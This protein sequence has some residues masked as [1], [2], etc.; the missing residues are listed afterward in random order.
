MRDDEVFALVTV[1]AT[2]LLGFK[3][4]MTHQH[5]RETLKTVQ[6]VVE[7]GHLDEGTR[8]VLADS[9]VAESRR[10]REFWQMVGRHGLPFLRRTMFVASWLC[11]VIS[12]CV[13]IAMLATD[14]S[15]WE[16]QGAGIFTAI[17]FGLITVPMAMREIEGRRA[18]VR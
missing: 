18:P 1:M 6:K 10:L 8:R 14:A 3:M 2:G 7:S 13:L 4:W 17:G 9:L 15:R 5:R 12:G 16:I 11:F